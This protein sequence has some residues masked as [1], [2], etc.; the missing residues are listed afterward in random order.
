MNIEDMKPVWG[1]AWWHQKLFIKWMGKDIRVARSLMP[2]ESFERLLVAR[3]KHTRVLKKR[4]GLIASWAARARAERM[5]GL[6][7]EDMIYSEKTWKM[8]VL[9]IEEMVWRIMYEY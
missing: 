7:V 1:V 6:A 4:R 2:R 3:E 5:S 8:N 9:E